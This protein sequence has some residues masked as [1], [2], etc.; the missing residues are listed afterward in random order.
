MF[1]CI[2]YF[3]V[4]LS[5]ILFPAFI[6]LSESINIFQKEIFVKQKLKNPMKLVWISNELNFIDDSHENSVFTVYES[7][8]MNLFKIH[9]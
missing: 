8:G 5:G 7:L 1:F 9:V 3:Q 6:L 4:G 2:V